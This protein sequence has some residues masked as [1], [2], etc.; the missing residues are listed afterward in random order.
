[1]DWFSLW[2]LTPLLTIFQLYRGS[3]FYWW[4]KLETTFDLSQVT[5][6]HYHIMLTSGCFYRSNNTETV[7]INSLNQQ[8]VLLVEKLDFPEKTTEM[9]QVTNK[10]YHN[11]LYHVHLAWAGFKL[12]STAEIGTDCTCSCKSNYHMIKTTKAPQHLWKYMIRYM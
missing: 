11:M 7:C 10:L 6:K 3:Q 1:M 4:R 5:D 8:P 12:K 9:S 2:W